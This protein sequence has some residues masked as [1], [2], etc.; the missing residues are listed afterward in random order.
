MNKCWNCGV[1][2]VD[3]TNVCPLCKCITE[4]ESEQEQMRE[5]T[6][7]HTDKEMKKIQRALNIYTFAAIVAEVFFVGIDFNTGENFWWSIMLGAFFVYGFITLKF[8]VQKH[9]GY[10]F[11]M[12]LQ[13]LLGVSVV[14]LID[15]LLGFHGW[16]LNYVL[17]AVFMLLDVAVIVLMI[18]NN[19]NWQSYI[20]MQLLIIVLCLIPLVLSYLGFS[21]YRVVDAIALGVA[22]F[23]FVGTLIVGG[24]RARDELYRRFHV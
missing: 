22:V 1:E 2:F 17:P 15:Y 10:Q 3:P 20:P 11:K 19:R 23:V 16:S 6:Y 7:P 12:L 9:I 21:L 5:P 4:N 24:K 14:I 13:T 18:A 8:S